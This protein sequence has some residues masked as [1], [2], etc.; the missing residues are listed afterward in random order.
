MVKYLVW[1]DRD[2]DEL[3]GEVAVADI[4]EKILR[5]IFVNGKDCPLCNAYPL[6]NNKLT[7]MQRL[8]GD[9]TELCPKKY[10]YFLEVFRVE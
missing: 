3:K 2:T 1:Y 9:R 7:V 10:E 4:D 5:Y 8:I 6:P